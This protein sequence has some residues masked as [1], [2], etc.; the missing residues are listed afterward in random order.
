M[1]IPFD[2]LLFQESEETLEKRNHDL[3]A[4]N[5]RLKKK[6][7]SLKSR[8]TSSNSSN[9]A[10]PDDDNIILVR[11][12]YNWRFEANSDREVNNIQTKTI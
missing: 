4:E 3:M 11:Y 5:E 1:N 6:I 8:P 10:S 7:E 2:I 9:E 12:N